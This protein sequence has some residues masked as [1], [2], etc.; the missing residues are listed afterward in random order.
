M[1]EI[2]RTTNL[3]K[4]FGNL[5]AVDNL[6]LSVRRGEIL[7]FL[8]L[9]GAGKT[10]TIRMLLGMISPTAGECFLKDQ[11][12]KVSDTNI[13]SEVGYLVETTYSYPNLT[14]RENLDIVRKLRDIEDKKCVDEIIEKLKLGSYVSVKS[15]NLSLGNAQRL[16]VAKALIHKPKILLLDEPTNG[17]DPAGIVE[18]RSLLL[19]LAVNHGVSMIVSSHKLEEIAKIATNMAIIHEGRLIKN[20]TIT[21]LEKDLKKSLLVDGKD[22][23]AV[24]S[25][26]LEAGYVINK[27]K[28]DKIFPLEIFSE[29]ATSNPEKIVTRLVNYGHPPNLL[30]VKTEDLETYFMRTIQEEGECRNE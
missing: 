30:K 18:I 2:I 24:R 29:E 15:K 27:E 26:L 6:N 12:V 19:D 7:G 1:E 3:T 14:V 17:L 22:R 4:K 13:W 23:Q 9:N 10:T 8:G 16:G 25:I 20:L 21:E 5:W 28:D 11:K